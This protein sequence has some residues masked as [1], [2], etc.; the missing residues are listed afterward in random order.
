MA[1]SVNIT[2]CYLR[3]AQPDDIDL[4]YNWANDPETRRNSFNQHVISREEHE[5]W[6][7]DMMS[8][9]NRIQYILM[10]GDTPVGQI[11]ID[12]TGDTAEI[13]YSIAPCE[14]GKGY[15]HRIIELAKQEV[16]KKY[17]F[18]KTLKAS[19][20][21][22][23]QTSMSCFVDNGFIENKRVYVAKTVNITGGADKLN[24]NSTAD[25]YCQV[26]AA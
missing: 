13:S 25:I 8:D 1:D 2:E 4:L 11:R 12:I 15:G 18:I 7:A 10:S 16:E 5:A 9:L 23:N 6:F 19:V 26:L 20:K 17:P 21:P 3:R 22:Q 14:R 24:A